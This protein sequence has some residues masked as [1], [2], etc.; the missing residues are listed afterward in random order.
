METSTTIRKML[1]HGTLFVPAY[2]RAYSW[3]KNNSALGNSIRRTKY[4]HVLVEACAGIIV[5]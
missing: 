1:R 5:L 4:H 2:Q 3:D